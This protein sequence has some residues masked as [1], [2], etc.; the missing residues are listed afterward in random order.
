MRAAAAAAEKQL[1]VQQHWGQT[2]APSP[3]SS[4]PSSCSPSSCLIDR[5]GGGSSSSSRGVGCG[6]CLPL[7]LCRSGGELFGQVSLQLQGDGGADIAGGKVT[8]L[9]GDP[10]TPIVRGGWAGAGS[11][12]CVC[13]G[14][15]VRAPGAKSS[16]EGA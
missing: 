14:G 5:S 2:R 1:A 12:L 4:S 7:L 10:R 9:R 3:P 8:I 15:H 11:V 13:K 16:L 6:Q